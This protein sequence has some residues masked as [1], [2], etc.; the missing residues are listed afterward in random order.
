MSIINTIAREIHCK[1]LYCG[2]E[3]AGKKSSIA[4]VR[5]QFN[6]QKKDFFILPFEK[7]V[8]CLVVSIG[9]VFGFKTFFH[10]YNLSQESKEDDENLL[11]GTDGILFVA[12]S[13]HQERNKNIESLSQIE[14]ALKKEGKDLFKIPLVFQYNKRD[15]EDIQSVK[16]LKVDLNKYNKKDFESSVLKAEKILEPL[17]Y[18]CKLT[19]NDLKQSDL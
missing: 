7:E 11:Q 6:R 19:L 13:L 3:Q 8:Y 5:D 9:E 10:I 17:K 18:L 12:S 2:P 4:Y 16:Q 1:I 14:K 15:L